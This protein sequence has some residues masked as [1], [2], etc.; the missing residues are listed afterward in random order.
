MA[1]EE[2]IIRDRL[3]VEE[4]TLRR[5]TRKHATFINFLEQGNLKEA[6]Q[7]YNEFLVD[8]STYELSLAR[9]QIIHDM[10]IREARHWEE[11]A[12][13]IE[14]EIEEI[15]KVIEKL[16]K[17][18]KEEE[19]IRKNK[20]EYDLLATEINEHQT[21]DESIEEITV[22][23]DEIKSL[24]EK[25][26]V[27]D[28]IMKRR[29]SQIERILSVVSEIQTE[30]QVDHEQY[31]SILVDNEELVI[32]P[33]SVR[34]EFASPIGSPIPPPPEIIP[35]VNGLN[36]TNENVQNEN[37]VSDVDNS[38][39]NGQ[40]ANGTERMITPQSNGD[41]S[42]DTI[43]MNIDDNSLLDRENVS[44]KENVSSP[45][46]VVIDISQ[47]H[48]ETM[49]DNFNEEGAIDGD[50]EQSIVEDLGEVVEEENNA[51]IPEEEIEE[52]GDIAVSEENERRSNSHE[53]GEEENADIPI[54]DEGEIVEDVEEIEY[55]INN[56]NRKRKHEHDDD[57]I[58]GD[59]TNGRKRFLEIKDDKEEE[60]G[61]LSDKL[62]HSSG[63]EN[64][65]S[66][67]G[68]IE[69]NEDDDNDTIEDVDAN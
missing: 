28:E 54:V 48:E 13:K 29:Y 22:L 59:S 10:N 26:K 23:D 8:F 69:D 7:N 2:L 35:Q 6:R 57:D 4:R 65:Y 68:V 56:N 67:E 50:D 42:P 11:E 34:S 44:D 52:V 63:P 24:E 39:N 37:S 14:K 40:M 64:E 17:E 27:I 61:V 46:N 60:E 45:S 47:N 51:Y 38:P 20:V 55:N 3:A 25:E 21:R 66:D 36:G 9:F 19:E 33:E 5:V 31:R 49:H 30:I 53:R 1:D 41:D 43:H 16:E 15:K 12:K 62:P 58:E 18:L 32:T